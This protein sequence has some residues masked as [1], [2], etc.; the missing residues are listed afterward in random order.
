MP[1]PQRSLKIVHD[2]T[3]TRGN[4][5]NCDTVGLKIVETVE[6]PRLMIIKTSALVVGR[7]R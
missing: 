4:T 6:A 3:V 1:E 2:S 7:E 5:E